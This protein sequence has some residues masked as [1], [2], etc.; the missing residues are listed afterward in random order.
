[1]NAV[2]M[3]FLLFEDLDLENLLCAGS[4]RLSSTVD[5]HCIP[6]DTLTVPTLPHHTRQFSLPTLTPRT[7]MHNLMSK[8]IAINTEK[9]PARLALISPRLGDAGVFIWVW[10]HYSRKFVCGG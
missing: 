3:L 8:N 1:M 5:I 10:F 6:V 7:I 4:R 9:P 2:P